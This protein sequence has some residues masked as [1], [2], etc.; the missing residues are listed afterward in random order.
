[1]LLA[2]VGHCLCGA[3]LLGVSGDKAPQTQQP[4]VQRSCQLFLIEE[5]SPKLLFKS[6]LSR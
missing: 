4:L 2:G 3:A 1:M 5:I 6:Q